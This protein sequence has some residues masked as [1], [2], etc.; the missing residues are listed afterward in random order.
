M[1]TVFHFSDFH[2]LPQRGMTREEGDPCHKIE[3][4]IQLAKETEIKP[5]FS[6]I[7]GD[8]SQDGATPGYEIAKEYISQIESL[9]GPVL[10]VMGN[11][12]NRQRFRENLLKKPATDKETP[13]YYCR[14]VNG[15]RVIALDSQ[16]PGKHTGH[17]DD[18]QLQWLSEQLLNEYTPTLIALHH[19]PFPFRIPNGGT[20]QVFDQASMT[21]FQ[22]IVEDSNV[23]AVLCGHFHQSLFIGY[24]DVRYIV[25]CAALSELQIGFNSFNIYDSFGFT[26]IT[27]D[28]NQLNIRPIIYSEGRPQISSKKI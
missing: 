1:T 8:I 23:L 24:N 18:E 5:V 14:T 17:L 22:E 11:V 25:G 6:V 13:C 27:L 28:E 7:T 9:G 10:P 21:R 16:N 2:I 26:Q 12:D 3:K 4:I 15:I 19:P 20:H